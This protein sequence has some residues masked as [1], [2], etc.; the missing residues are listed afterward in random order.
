MKN[1]LS[2]LTLCA[3]AF[4]RL[5]FAEDRPGVGLLKELVEIESGTSQIDEVNHV[6]DI[7]AD[8]LK[9]LGFEV[10]LKA[11]PLGDSK[12]GKFLVATLVGEN[13][14]YIN[15]VLHADTVFEPKAE[16]KGF[17]ISP[18]GKTAK[19]PGVIDDKGGAVVVL[20]GIERYLKARPKPAHSLRVISSPSEETGT[21]GF[22]EDLQKMADDTFVTLGF[23]PALDEHTIIESR[24]G[25]RW[26]HIKVTGK[27]A[28][29]GRAHKEGINAC[30][31]LAQKLDLLSRL[32]DYGKDVTVSIGRM[33]G[34]KDKFNIVCGSAE[35]KVDAR[36]SDLRSRDV[37]DKKIVAILKKP[38]VKSAADRK[39]TT[40]EFEIADDC[41]PFSVSKA[42]KPLL[43]RY[44]QIAGEIEKSTIKSAKSG[45]G[46]DSSYF[47]R[48]GG[49]VIDGLGAV[50][51]KMHTNDEF[52]VLSSLETRAAALAKFLE[53]TP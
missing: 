35:A 24:R 16:F 21:V 51:G 23:E 26:Y 14:R 43:E 41:P 25:N 2:L 8:H 11:N 20:G 19:G 28:H 31:D 48:E 36:F 38:L 53:A 27:E 5:G 9:K 10:L 47:A 4:T 34:G 6:Q 15:F 18:D 44:C 40:T 50:G 33:E 52:V 22:L 42:S 12:S 46:A 7:L 49:I 30:W 3:L 17:E 45:G 1:K 37:L 32:T 29:A 13:S 39:A